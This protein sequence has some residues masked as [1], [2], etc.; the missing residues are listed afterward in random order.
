MLTLPSYAVPIITRFF[1]DYL[2]FWDHVQTKDHPDRE[3]TEI[4]IHN[5]IR[6]CQD[7]LSYNADQTTQ[8]K[9]R[10]AF[11]DSLKFLKEQAEH[12]VHQNS[13]GWTHWNR[14]LE[15]KGDNKSV[16]KM[17]KL[18]LNVSRELG[19]TAKGGEAEVAATMLKVALDVA[20]TSVLTVCAQ[21]LRI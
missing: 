5:H 3:F 1:A 4:Q 21:P 14:N 6:N 18:G 17:R 15:T 9:R 7:F 19:K 8:F 13:S 10:N 20:H 12:G 11:R 16:V 2:G